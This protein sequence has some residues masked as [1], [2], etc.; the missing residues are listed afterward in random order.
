MPAMEAE[1]LQCLIDGQTHLNIFYRILGS[2]HHPCILFERINN[3]GNYEPNNIRWA[4][5]IEQNHNRRVSIKFDGQYIDIKK[6]AADLKIHPRTI[7]NL[8]YKANFNLNEIKDFSKMTHYQKIQMGKSIKNNTPLTYIELTKVVSPVSPSPK[9]H[10]LWCTWHSMKQ[11]CNNPKNKDYK[12][13]GGKGIEVCDE[14]HAFE[15]FL[16][17]ILKTIGPKPSQE[18]QL[19]RIDNNKYYEPNNVRWATKQQQARNKNATVYLSGIGISAEEL[20]LRYNIYRRTVIT[21]LRLGWNEDGLK[22]FAQLT[23]KAKKHLKIVAKELSQEAA[24]TAYTRL[25]LS[26]IQNKK[27]QI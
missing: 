22:F 9:R 23:F 15:G 25:K 11:R 7:K 5:P 17:S 27:A 26:H 2:N 3:N 16:E 4:L 6:L 18:Y 1:E 10:P 24:T 8:M 14:W 19:D 20:S 21:L 12:N 13:Y